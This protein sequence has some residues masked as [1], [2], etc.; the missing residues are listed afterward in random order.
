MD[1]GVPQWLVVVGAVLAGVLWLLDI[2]IRVAALGIIPGNRKP[3][4]GVAWLLMVLLAPILGLIAFLLFGSTRVGRAR[5]EKQ[6][7]VNDRLRSRLESRDVPTP[8]GSPYLESVITLNNRLGALPM[9]E[10]NAVRFLEEYDGSILAMAAEVREARDFVHVEFYIC[11]WDE[12]T[13]PLFEAMADAAE[14]G[15]QVRFLYDH[16][17]SRGLPSYKAMLKRLRGTQIAWHPMLPIQL[18]RGN[19]RRPDLRNHRKL[20]VVD[21]RVGFMGSQNL[22]EP[23]YNKPKNHKLGRAWVELMVRVEGPVV[24]CLEA[25]FASDWYAETDEVLPL[26]ELDTVSAELP[27]GPRRATAWRLSQPSW[28][29]AARGSCRRTTC[30]CSRR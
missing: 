17:G 22:T 1:A 9:T 25:V 14:R 30:G 12:V 23:G 3:S 4:T 19:V 11:A 6:E 8:A 28:C 2:G 7:R 21:G 16:L 18:L 13:A 29:R 26:S 5:H 20:L 24:N 10:G 27:T 15:V